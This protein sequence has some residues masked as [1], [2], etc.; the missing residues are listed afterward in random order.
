MDKNAL[1][2]EVLVARDG[3]I[4]TLTFNRPEARNAMTWNMYERLYQHC[5]EVDSDDSITVPLAFVP[6]SLGGERLGNLQHV[7]I[8]RSSPREVSGVELE[9][10][11][12]SE[13]RAEEADGDAL[14]GAACLE[15]G[16]IGSGGCA[17]HRVGDVFAGR[18]S[19]EVP[20]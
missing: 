5:E 11:R 19:R 10:D 14:V 6:F 18:A 9:V 2:S 8:E 3:P 1:A 15:H 20:H 17:R 12:T 16:G 13:A 7:T 4:L